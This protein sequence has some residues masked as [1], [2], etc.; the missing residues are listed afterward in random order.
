MST[1]TI[2]GSEDEEEK[3]ISERGNVVSSDLEVEKPNA[4]RGKIH[5]AAGE[6]VEVHAKE[7]GR[8]MQVLKRMVI[9]MELSV[10]TGSDGTLR[11]EDWKRMCFHRTEKN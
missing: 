7:F 3:G 5:R 8:L 10:G 6:R 11:R 9:W 1:G 4:L 2:W